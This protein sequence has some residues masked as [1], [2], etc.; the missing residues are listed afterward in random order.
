MGATLFSLEGL[1]Y[2][3]WGGR[4]LDGGRCDG[5][6][7]DP[8][9]MVVGEEVQ[10]V[11]A[12][13]GLVTWCFKHWEAALSARLMVDAYFKKLFKCKPNQNRT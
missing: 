2:Y 13:V 10:R 5:V 1:R 6:R 12:L 7:R 9:K 3:R 4:G 11:F 8:L